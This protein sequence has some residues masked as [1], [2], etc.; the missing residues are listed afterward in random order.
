MAPGTTLTT[1]GGR[2]SS[3][4]LTTSGGTVTKAGIGVLAIPP[5]TAVAA[6][7]TINVNQGTLEITNSPAGTTS[8]GGAPLQLSG[9]TLAVVLC[10]LE[11]AR[12]A[13][14]VRQ[15]L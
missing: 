7:T 6:G 3:G 11:T 14:M 1:T 13:W 10:R 12:P 15:V 5:G 9:G 4:P 8:I 2:L